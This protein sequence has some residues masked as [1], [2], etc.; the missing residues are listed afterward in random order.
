MGNDMS[1]HMCIPRCGRSRSSYHTSSYS[2]QAQD[3]TPDDPPS[4]N[5]RELSA[6]EIVC[7]ANDRCNQ[8]NLPAQ[9][10]GGVRA[11]TVPVDNLVCHWAYTVM[12]SW[13]WI[14]KAWY[15][16]LPPAGRGRQAA[17]WRERKQAVLRMEFRTVGNHFMRLPCPVLKTGRRIVDRLLGWNP[18]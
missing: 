7:S 3:A 11:L 5:D 13:A 6:T 4:T 17:A 15:A 1:S 14:L 9:L 16:L 10:K 2:E 12:T 8:E 18:N